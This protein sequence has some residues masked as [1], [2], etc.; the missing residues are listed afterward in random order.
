MESTNRRAHAGTECVSY[1]RRLKI[2]W[3]IDLG[4]ACEI[5]MLGSL[6]R[7]IFQKDVTKD[8]LRKIDISLI[9]MIIAWYV[10][11]GLK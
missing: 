3:L 5:W 2:Y 7:S 9:V 11:N 4:R 6:D 10:I 8:H 1:A